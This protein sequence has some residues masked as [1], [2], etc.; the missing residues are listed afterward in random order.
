M[1]VNKIF[2]TLCGIL[3]LGNI[4]FAQLEDCTIDVG[5]FCTRTQ[6]GWGAS[7][8]GGNAGCIL[9]NNFATVFPTGLTVGGGFTIHF[10]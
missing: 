7:C 10:S 4:A 1:F 9:Q 3:L 2:S 8:N 6:G 5:D